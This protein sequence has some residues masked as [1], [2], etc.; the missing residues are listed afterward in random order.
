MTLHVREFCGT[1]L[2]WTVLLQTVWDCHISQLF[3]CKTCSQ[4]PCPWYG[5]FLI[6][7]LFFN[8]GS[9]HVI[10]SPVWSGAVQE[11]FHH[12]IPLIIAWLENSITWHGNK[13]QLLAL[14]KI[15]CISPAR[16][17]TVYSKHALQH[18][19]QLK[20]VPQ[21]VYTTHMMGGGSLVLCL[22]NQ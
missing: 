12:R 22:K 11:E 6:Y 7:G 13:E 9:R 3:P 16:L 19:G 15:F 5:S 10:P 17:K 1:A 2:W 20:S 21:T 8:M 14:F 4:N 18:H